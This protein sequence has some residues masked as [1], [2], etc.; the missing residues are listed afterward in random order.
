MTQKI[1]FIEAEKKIVSWETSQ[2]CRKR[3]LA[4][5]RVR[6]TGNDQILGSLMNIETNYLIKE[7]AHDH[8][9]V[10]KLGMS[11]QSSEIKLA[12]AILLRVLTFKKVTFKMNRVTGGPENISRIAK[13]ISILPLGY[14]YRP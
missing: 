13:E 2:I 5:K 12:S 6:F 7:E 1:I 14:C 3:Q 10:T 4:K 8:G 9:K 11:L